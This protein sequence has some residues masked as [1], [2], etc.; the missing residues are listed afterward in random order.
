MPPLSKPSS[1]TRSQQLA[2]RPTS[3]CPDTHRESRL[4][5]LPRV[6]IRSQD[7][8]V[9]IGLCIYLRAGTAGVPGVGDSGAGMR[10]EDAGRDAGRNAG[11]DAEGRLAQL[12]RFA[13]PIVRRGWRGPGLRN[14]GRCIWRR[15]PG[16][17]ALGSAGWGPD[18]SIRS[19]GTE[20]AA[21]RLCSGVLAPRAPAPVLQL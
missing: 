2:A 6:T 20:A 17:R 21:P 18:A 8:R 5:T 3:R 19:S 14:A 9:R 10:C 7:T 1:K 12:P 4:G 13:D 15:A 11:R 16:L